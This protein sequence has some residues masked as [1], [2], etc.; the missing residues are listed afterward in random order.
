MKTILYSELIKYYV[1]SHYDISW[2]GYC[3][4]EGLICSFITRD[5]TDYQKMNDE[6]PIC[7]LDSID[8][9]MLY[10][11]CT[12]ESYKDVYVDVYPLSFL[13]RMKARY[14][15]FYWF[16]FKVIYYHLKFYYKTRK[17]S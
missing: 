12:C 2:K 3:I 15:K 9:F 13:Q 10:R 17:L 11:E 6:C 16:N 7:T 8:G 4:H 5:E 1:T 14:D